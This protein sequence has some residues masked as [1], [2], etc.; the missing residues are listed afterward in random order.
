[1]FS[2]IYLVLMFIYKLE[3]LEETIILDVKYV[4]YLFYRILSQNLCQSRICLFSIGFLQ[5]QVLFLCGAKLYLS[6]QYRFSLGFWVVRVGCWVLEVVA[7][8]SLSFQVL[9][10]AFWVFGWVTLYRFCICRGALRCWGSSLAPYYFVITL[11]PLGFLY[12]QYYLPKKKKKVSLR[13]RFYFYVEL[14]S[15]LRSE[16]KPHR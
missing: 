2:F 1:M 13:F 3:L 4:A 8:G 10:Y 11:C 9:G 14:N 5:V 16:M 6:L 15:Q 7:L 12:I